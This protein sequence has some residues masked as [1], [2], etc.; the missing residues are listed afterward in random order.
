METKWTG[1]TRLPG[2]QPQDLLRAPDIDRREARIWIEFVR[3]TAI[4]DD[5]IEVVG[6]RGERLLSQ[7]ETR[8]RQVAGKPDDSVLKDI[9]PQ[10]M[11]GQRLAYPRRGTRLIPCAH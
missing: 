11:E 8:L 4:V 9:V 2:C 3:R 6:K 5:H 7:S 10:A 1:V